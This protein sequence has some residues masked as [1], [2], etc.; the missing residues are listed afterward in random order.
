MAGPAEGA[1]GVEMVAL[2]RQGLAREGEREVLQIIAGIGAILRAVSTSVDQR[3]S[4]ELQT[5]RQELQ[6]R[7]KRTDELLSSMAAAA[8][9]KASKEDV[10]KRS[11][12]LEEARAKESKLRHLLSQL[13]TLQFEVSTLSQM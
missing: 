6:G 8:T 12:L 2:S 13:R 7:F 5:L 3:S 10:A 4:A 11:E 1:V 9:E